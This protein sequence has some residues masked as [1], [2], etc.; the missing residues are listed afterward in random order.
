MDRDIFMKVTA[1]IEYRGDTRNYNEC[2]NI[3]GRNED[4]NT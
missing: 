2:T 1:K 4:G 3:L